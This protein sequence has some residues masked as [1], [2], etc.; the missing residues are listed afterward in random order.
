M[1]SGRCFVFALKSVQNFLGG[2][3]LMSAA[4]LFAPSVSAC[5]RVSDFDTTP[6][7]KTPQQSELSFANQ[8]KQLAADLSQSPQL[9]ENLVSPWCSTGFRYNAQSKLCENDRQ[10][11]G[12]FTLSMIQ[13]CQTN[14]GGSACQQDRWEKGFASRLR[15][16]QRCPRGAAWQ[17]DRQACQEGEDV[18]G[19]F[20]VEWVQRCRQWG[21]G[22][23]CESNRWH[24][25]FAPVVATQK[26]WSQKLVEYYQKQENY[27]KVTNDVLNWFGTRKFGCV[28]FVSTA[29]RHVG[30]PVPQQGAID[31][32]EIS[33]WTTSLTKFLI[34]RGWYKF[35]DH[36]K[37]QPGDIVFTVG[38]EGFPPGVPAHTYV[39]QSWKDRAGKIGW[40][41]DNQ[42]FTHARDIFSYVNEENFSP[43]AYAL[44]SVE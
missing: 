19:P 21:G 44:R 40:V 12:P 20:P 26:K 32:Y 17:A 14:G 41:I 28:A 37:L 3:L 11:Q 36:T 23:V 33:R 10:A 1:L 18:F 9:V 7:E 42:G 13:L 27:D 25:S 39:F 31:G 6:P 8:N 43:F 4:A 38:G 5:G 22:S 34:R 16:D 35:T 30:Y 24:K 15:G 29:L 2:R